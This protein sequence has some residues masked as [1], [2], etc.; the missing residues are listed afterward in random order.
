MPSVGVEDVAVEACQR[1]VRSLDS[2]HVLS[3]IGAA[4]ES[5]EGF[6]FLCGTGRLLPCLAV[7]LHAARPS[8]GG[9]IRALRLSPSARRR[10][11]SAPASARAAPQGGAVLPWDRRRRFA[12]SR[13]NLRTG[14]GPLRRLRLYAARSWARLLIE[15][16][17]ASCASTALERNSWRTLSRT[18]RSER[19][20][21]K[22]SRAA[23][24]R[25]D[26]K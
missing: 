8:L 12:Q 24:T 17:K 7:E 9:R 1:L 13:K 2:R 15:R 18:S 21:R 6:G 22:A 19:T 20:L 25:M 26:R 5:V 11:Q 23:G 4:S 3:F 14:A 16:S 10:P